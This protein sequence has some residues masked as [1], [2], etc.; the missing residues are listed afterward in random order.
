MDEYLVFLD[1][2]VH[3]GRAR[4]NGD[5]LFVYIED[6]PVDLSKAFYLL[7]DP[8]NVKKITYHYYKAA[9]IFEGF[10]ELTS[11]QNDGNRIISVLKKGE[12]NDGEH[13]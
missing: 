10:T 7:S 5:I 2:T 9:L 12:L 13:N 8:E 3:A 4:E 6:K 1:E 11:I